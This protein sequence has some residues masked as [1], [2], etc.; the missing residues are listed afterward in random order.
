[1][2][3]LQGEVEFD[4]VPLTDGL[5][6]ATLGR[7]ADFIPN[8]LTFLPKNVRRCQSC[9]FA[10]FNFDI[11]SEPPKIEAVGLFDKEAFSER[12]ISWATA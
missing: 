7:E 1:L 5:E 3:G 12:F 11:R 2:F 9:I 8:G 4:M 6:D 10:Q